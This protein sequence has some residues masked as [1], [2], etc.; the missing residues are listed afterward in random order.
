MAPGDT[1]ELAVSILNLNG[2]VDLQNFKWHPLEKLDIPKNDRDALNYD[3]DI[4]ILYNMNDRKTKVHCNTNR[5]CEVEDAVPEWIVA[6][7]EFR[8]QPK[9]HIDTNKYLSRFDVL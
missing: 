9:L 2:L 6:G 7:K 4:K 1:I 3:R 8:D 5:I